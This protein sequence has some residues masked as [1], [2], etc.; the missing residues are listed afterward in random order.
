MREIH[1]LLPVVGPSRFAD[2]DSRRDSAPFFWRARGPSTRATSSSKK[3]TA[4]GK[5]P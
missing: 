3:A 1:D 5:N 4:K 2:L